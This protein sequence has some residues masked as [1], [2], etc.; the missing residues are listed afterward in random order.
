MGP[1]PA[2]GGVTGVIIHFVLFAGWNIK[3]PGV[4]PERVPSELKGGDIKWTL[5]VLVADL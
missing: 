2:K 5:H 4:F 3:D 1:I